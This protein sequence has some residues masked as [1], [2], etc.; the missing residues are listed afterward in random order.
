M[1]EPQ[2]SPAIGFR[3]LVQPKS[4]CL[5]CSEED[6]T[7][8]GKPIAHRA[9]GLPG[10]KCPGCTDTEETGILQT[11]PIGGRTSAVNSDIGGN[12][13][14]IKG[15]GPLSQSSRS[16]F[17]PRFGHNFGHVRVHNNAEASGAARRLNAE[18]F[19]V[20]SD[21]YFGE[22][23]YQPE[24]RQGMRLLAHE[25]THTI[26]QGAP[27]GAGTLERDRLVQRLSMPSWDDVVDAGAGAVDWAGDTASDAVDWAG[28]TAS[29]AVD[30]AG[31]TASDA[32]DWA[33]DAAG[34]A[35]DWILSTA[36]QA[37]LASAN[38]LAGLFGGSVRVSGTCLI[39]T[40]GN[41]DLFDSFNKQLGEIPLGGFYLP[42]LGGGTMIGPF[43]VAGTV[44]I[45]GYA[46]GSLEAAVG[47]GLLRNI[48]VEICPFSD[49]YTATAQFYAAA[50]IGA[51]LSLFGGLAA[52]VATII[53]IEPPIPL[54]G[55]IQGGLRG[56]GTGWIVGAAQDTVTLTYSGGRLSFLNVTDLMAGVLLQGDL[57]IFAALRFFE[58]IICQ[59]VYPLGHWETGRA[60][61]LTIPIFAGLGGGRKGTG[62]I[63][64]ITYG[65]M[66]IEDIE[67]AIGPLPTGWDCLN[68]AEIKEFLCDLGIL[69]DLICEDEEEDGG[70][71]G[72]AGKTS[73]CA[74]CKCSGD[75][76]CGGGRIHTIW[77]GKTDC[78]RENKKKAQRLCNH[79]KTFL[80]ICDL[81]Q[82]RKDG[83]KCSVHHHDFA[84]GENETK[85]KCNN[86]KQALDVPSA[87]PP[88]VVTMSG[89]KCGN[90]YGALGKYCYSGTQN[91]WFKEKVKNGPGPLCQ[92]GNINQTTQ[93][94]QSS[95]GCVV[96][97]IFNNNGP[98][99]NVAPCDDTTFQT[100]FAGPTKA[101]VEKC[102]YKNTQVIKVSVTKGSNPKSGKVKT[103]SAGVSTECDWP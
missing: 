76:E 69:P 62:G 58:K 23:R 80:S 43:P 87:C 84:C 11:K 67:T 15:G 77:M 74:I 4:A 51:R 78:N 56:T 21:I 10:Q 64:P 92:P 71:P 55:I 81:N 83:K 35:A 19:T 75:K 3:S 93:P 34:D 47:P 17:E 91:W 18:A 101:D 96:D 97:R 33:G 88:Q 26:Q 24:T 8:R 25:L 66:P 49:R 102:Q 16:F 98:P 59:Y 29:D 44:G 42:L 86:R 2:P 65:P 50:A 27:G 22:G 30:W 90:Q 36:G 32:V 52:G 38:A 5:A 82:K 57:D 73:A 68:W 40:I 12:I 95:T 13:N 89:A 45:L 6:K 60:W 9:L 85:A 14:S 72:I 100:V 20:G 31:D 61:K 94:I 48:R 63:G 39:I 70:E 46:L 28:D 41:I 37:A 1:P 53:P 103:T 7:I 99:A 79:D 54:V